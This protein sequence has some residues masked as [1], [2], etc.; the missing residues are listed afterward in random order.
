MNNKWYRNHRIEIH[1]FFQE[2][3]RIN[4]KIKQQSSTDPDTNI[5]AF[6]GSVNQV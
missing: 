4:V 3:K 6:N 2:R 5:D 1:C